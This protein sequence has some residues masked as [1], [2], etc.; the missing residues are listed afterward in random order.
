MRATVVGRH[1]R[2]ATA[3]LLTIA[4][5]LAGCAGGPGTT[6]SINAGGD[7]G[8]RGSLRAELDDFR[9][10]VAEGAIAG[11]ILGGI[12]G[13]VAGRGDPRRIIAGAAAGGIAGAGVG[14][15]IA[16]QKQQFATREEALDAIIADGRQ[17]TARLD[18]LN[19]SADRLLQQRR[20]ELARINASTANAHSKAAERRRIAAELQGDRSEV[21]E[22]LAISRKNT[23]IMLANV[24]EFRRANPG[25]V[26]KQ[27]DDMLG[28]QK[29]S[30]LSL[31]EKAELMNKAILESTRPLNQA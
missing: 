22:A 20:A 26:S 24:Q 19:R 14:Y 3:V 21:E 18:N 27:L 11:A 13:A 15:M 4:M 31:A 9:Q 23:E 2:A 12:I 28:E 29:K 10:T 17:R 7:G 25:V 16:G 5:M 30:E 1:G 8:R 6:A